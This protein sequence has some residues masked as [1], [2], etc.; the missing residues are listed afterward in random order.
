[1]ATGR[2]IAKF[3]TQKTGQNY[4]SLYDEAVKEEQIQAENTKKTFTKLVK[5]INE[6]DKKRLQDRY[7]N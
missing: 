2:D 4:V 5:R 6:C 7:N 3:L 1:M